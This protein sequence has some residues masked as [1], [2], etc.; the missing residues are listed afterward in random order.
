MNT[1]LCR[2]WDF[3]VIGLAR[4]AGRVLFELS[5]DIGINGVSIKRGP[6]IEPNYQ[7]P[8]N[9]NSQGMAPE[10]REPYVD[11]HVRKYSVKG[12]APVQLVRGTLAI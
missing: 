6:K 11:F 10:L 3:R 5:G 12:L 7:V 1:K 2:V 4:R 9:G 8:D